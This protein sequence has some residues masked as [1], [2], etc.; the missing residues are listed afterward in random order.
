MSAVTFPTDKKSAKKHK[1]LLLYFS[2][3]N[4]FLNNI[5]FIQI[6][7]SKKNKQIFKLSITLR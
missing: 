1:L 4:A 2:S 5:Q 6:L 3:L 7:T